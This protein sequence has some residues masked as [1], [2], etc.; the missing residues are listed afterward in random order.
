L[1]EI[2]LKVDSC[3]IRHGLRFYPFFGIKPHQRE[4]NVVWWDF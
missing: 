3:E 4:I 2:D 1:F